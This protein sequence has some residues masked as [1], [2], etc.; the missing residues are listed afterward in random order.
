VT[1]YATKDGC[2]KTDDL[3]IG[4]KR[5]VECEHHKRFLSPSQLRS[6]GVGAVPAPGQANVRGGV[7]SSTPRRRY[8]KSSEP[9]R[10][11]SL[12]IAKVEEEGC[13]RI[14]KRSDRKLDASHIL[15]REHDEP[16]IGADGRPL[17]ELFVHP[18]RIIPACGPYPLHCHGAQHRH[19]VDTLRYLTLDEQLMAVKDA[20]SIEAARIRLIPA[21][22]SAYV[23]GLA[24]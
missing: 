22:S 21:P 23:E 7:D 11:W 6:V 18:A 16:K 4:A 2:C 13:C 14:C 3:G 5:P 15:G 12:A 8:K 10:D 24:S 9:K 20:G 19:E 17:K 1:R